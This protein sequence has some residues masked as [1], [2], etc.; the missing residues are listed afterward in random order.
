MA[1]KTEKQRIDDV[2]D[3]DRSKDKF[4]DYRELDERVIGGI[5]MKGRTYKYVGYEWTQ[6][7]AQ[8]DDKRALSISMTF[9]D[10]AEGTVADRILNSMSI[11]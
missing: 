7:I 9:L 3:F 8:L 5:T 2:E 11:K 1:L 10:V 4:E 6:Y